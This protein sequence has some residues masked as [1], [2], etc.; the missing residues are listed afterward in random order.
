MASNATRVILRAMDQSDIRRVVLLSAAP[1]G[2]VPE[3]ESL[4]YRTVLY[5]LLRRI[6]RDPY[7]DLAAMEEEARRSNTEWTVIRP[8][9]LTD[10]PLTERYRREIGSN[11]PRGHFLSRAD[12]AHAMLAALE[13]PAT[14][15]QPVGV[16][17]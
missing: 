13:D 2:P 7:A 14:V 12:L 8:P 6:L 9:R 1:V 5:P 15:K 17:Y 4:I 11:V 10:K 16:A 3:G